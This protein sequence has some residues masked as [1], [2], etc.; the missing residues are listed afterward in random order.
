MILCTHKHHDHA[1]GKR[2]IERVDEKREFTS[3]RT[4][5]G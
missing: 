1:G 3:V 2:A 4:Q 5:V